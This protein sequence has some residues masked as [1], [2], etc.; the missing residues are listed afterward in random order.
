MVRPRR[1][2][3]IGCQ[4]GATFFKPAGIPAST[5]RISSVDLDELEAMRL[6]DDE[7]L[8]QT[9]AAERMKISQSTVARLLE[10]GRR[11]VADMLLRFFR[12]DALARKWF[13]R[14]P[15]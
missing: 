2:R 5:L 6:V 13:L 15:G 9:E 14:A 8:H 4:P 11:K 3:W 12:E 1:G 7:G 10:S